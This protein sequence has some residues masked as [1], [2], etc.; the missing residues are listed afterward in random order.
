MPPTLN[1][2]DLV[3]RI[4]RDVER[5]LLRARNGVRYVRGTHAPKVGA[6]PK[7]VVWQRG[8]ARAVALPQRAGRATARR[9]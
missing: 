5:S 9:C 1:P 2:V 8:K 7:E 4:N 6:T 3:S